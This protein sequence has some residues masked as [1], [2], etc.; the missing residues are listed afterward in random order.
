MRY[1]LIELYQNILAC[2]ADLTAQTK[3]REKI[4]HQ[5]HRKTMNPLKQISLN[6]IKSLSL[7]EPLKLINLSK[8][9]PSITQQV[10]NLGTS[11]R[12][13]HEIKPPRNLLGIHFVPQKRAYVVERFGKFIQ[14]LQPGLNFLIPLIDKIA[15]AHSLKE[16]AIPISD[17]TATTVDNVPI[18]IDGVLYIKIIDPFLASYG[19]ENPIFAVTQLAQTTMRSE[20]GKITLDKTFEERDRLNKN[21]LGAINNHPLKTH[22]GNW[23]VFVTR[24][25][26]LPLL[27]GLRWSCSCKLRLSAESA[28]RFWKLRGYYYSR[29]S[30]ITN[31][32]LLH[33]KFCDSLKIK[34][35]SF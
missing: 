30:L 7:V 21:I 16:Q 17:Q 8:P 31:K 12:D 29:L 11:R 20:L 2:Q 19:I 23:S 10:R 24:S 14:I 28:H 13:P 3:T 9:K 15:Y 33:G 18:V 5:N 6:N 1:Y 26:M 35:C 34:F 22:W 25:K 4:P 32:I 27:M